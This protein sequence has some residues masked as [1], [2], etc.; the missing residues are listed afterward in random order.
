MHVPCMNNIQASTGG[1]FNV[2]LLRWP[3]PNYLMV[4]IL[5]VFCL[6]C[7]ELTFPHHDMTKS[8]I[9][10]TPLFLNTLPTCGSRHQQIPSANGPKPVVRTKNLPNYTNSWYRSHEHN[11]HIHHRPLAPH[12]SSL[13]LL[14]EQ[15]H[16]SL[17]VGVTLVT[18]WVTGQKVTFFEDF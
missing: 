13:I 6:V 9:T 2:S 16:V 4:V 8:Q 3:M 14:I 15:P 5:G 10:F 12:P 7:F 1:V 17:L 18:F 11:T